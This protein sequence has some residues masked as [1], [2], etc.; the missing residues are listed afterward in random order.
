M[1][2]DEDCIRLDFGQPTSWLTMTSKQARD[3]AW[4]LM[5]KA[6]QL[7]RELRKGQRNATMDLG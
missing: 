1:A 5:I 2:I 7:D 3:W 4:E 6:N